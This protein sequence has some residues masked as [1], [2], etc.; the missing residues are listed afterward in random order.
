[1]LGTVILPE[2]IFIDRL[3]GE[4]DDQLT[5]GHVVVVPDIIGQEALLLEVRHRIGHQVVEAV[6]TPL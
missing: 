6:V 5:L 1:M 2:V 3:E 4:L